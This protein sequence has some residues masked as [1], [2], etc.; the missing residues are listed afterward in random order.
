[1]FADVLQNEKAN[2]SN[3]KIIN[4]SAIKPFWLEHPV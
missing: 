2:M 4:L 3:N 1:M